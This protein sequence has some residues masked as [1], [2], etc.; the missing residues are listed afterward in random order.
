VT[1]LPSLSRRTVRRSK[2]DV[3]L[4]VVWNALV[5]YMLLVLALWLVTQTFGV[6]PSAGQLLAGALGLLL[7]IAIT[8]STR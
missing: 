2:L 3:A 5:R 7:L 4:A 8:N 1:P 6:N